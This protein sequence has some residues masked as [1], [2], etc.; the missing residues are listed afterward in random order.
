MSAKLATA[1][2]MLGC[3]AD[4]GREDEAYVFVTKARAS[5]GKLERVDIGERIIRASVEGNTEW[6][7]VLL[8]VVIEDT[9]SKGPESWLRPRGVGGLMSFSR[10]Q[11]FSKRSLMAGSA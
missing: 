1:E 4:G 11:T 7:N 8:L 5:E 3:A 6:L 2:G 9:F 10:R